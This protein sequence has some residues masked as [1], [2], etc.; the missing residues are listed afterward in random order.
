MYQQ[1]TAFENIV[2]KQ[3]IARNEQF[4]LFPQCFL[5]NQIIVYPLFH[6]FDIISLLATKLKESIVGISDKG[7]TILINRERKIR[8]LC[9]L[10]TIPVGPPP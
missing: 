10:E 6:I 7:L 4:L 3:E 2:G 8:I 1:D 9:R 5:L